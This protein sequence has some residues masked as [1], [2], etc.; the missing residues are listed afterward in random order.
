MMDGSYSIEVSKRGLSKFTNK[1]KDI[2]YFVA[3][4]AAQ[5]KFE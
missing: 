3:I 4:E 5:S 1:D 2:E